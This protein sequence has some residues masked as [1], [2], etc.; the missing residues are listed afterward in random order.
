MVDPVSTAAVPVAR[1]GFHAWLHAARPATLPA[2]AVPVVV[3]TASAI[4]FTQVHPL[5]FT[6]ALTASVLIQI[7]TNFSNDY[8]DHRHGT[9]TEV[10]LGPIRLIQSGTVSAEGVLWAAIA[11][12]GLAA[13]IGLYLIYVGGLPIL[14]IGLLSILSGIAYTGG[15]WPLGYHG[16]GD[17]FVFIFFGL[18]AVCG[19][20]YLQTGHVTART[21]SAAIP[22]ALLVTAILVVNNLRDVDTDCRTGKNTLAVLIGKRRTRLQY[23]AFVLGAFLA[24][25][26]MWLAQAC[27]PWCWLTWLTLPLALR[28]VW[29]LCS[30]AEGSALNLALKRTGQLHLLFG[31][32]FAAALWL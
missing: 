28:V 29:T 10:R 4:G 5:T 17:L 6:A 27:S 24:P 18:I 14:V 31:L 1:S 15:P 2:A 22:V 8:F 23:A 12:F 21:L 25:P 16:L 7:G 19:S 30:G 20:A 11:S 13:L 9:D 3:G 32:L 26:L